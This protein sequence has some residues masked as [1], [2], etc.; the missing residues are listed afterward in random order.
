MTHLKQQNAIMKKVVRDKLGLGVWGF[1]KKGDSFTHEE[2]VY[3]FARIFPVFGFE[4]IK[5][6]RTSY[7]DCIAVKDDQEVSIEFE[8][9]LS[10]FADHV[11]KHDLKKCQYIVCWMDD[12][13]PYNSLRKKIADNNIAVIQ[14]KEYYEE[15]KVKSREI[16]LDWSAKEID[17]LK[18]NQIKAL[19]AFIASGKNILTNKEIGNHTNLKGKSIGGVLGGF[20]QIKKDWLVRKHPSGEWQFN[21]KYKQKVINAIKKFDI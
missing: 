8:P 12:L 6:V 14:L 2:I 15:G 13:E 21:K 9:K 18:I 19:S 20:T 17:R 4:Y 1:N 5:K 16:S 10:V 7:P 11:A 3:L